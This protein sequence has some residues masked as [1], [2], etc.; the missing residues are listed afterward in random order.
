MPDDDV[1]LRLFVLEHFLQAGYPPPV[2]RLMVEF[3][4][5]R[6]EVE[7]ALERLEAGRQLKLVPGTHRVLMAFPLSAVATPFRVTLGNGRSYFTNCAWD[8]IA[9]Y[10]ML[11]QPVVIESYCHHCASPIRLLLADGRADAGPRGPPLIYLGRPA[12]LW[13]DDII[14]TCSNTMLFFADAEHLNAW[15]EA[16]PGEHGEALTVPVVL[17]LSGPIYAGKLS[18]E[19]ARPDRERTRNLFRQLGL[20]G[21]FWEI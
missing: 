15:R 12:R 5:P 20:I 16:H 2:E 21:D 6:A 17:E 13:W 1:R 8:A 18:P 4:R 9:L 11:R 7:S 14:D 19:Y 10:V 3:D